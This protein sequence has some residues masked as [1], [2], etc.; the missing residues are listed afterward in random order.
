MFKLPGGV[1]SAFSKMFVYQ[2]HRVLGERRDDA[3]IQAGNR[4]NMAQH[5][6]SQRN[7]GPTT[8]DY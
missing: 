6:H 1:C 7:V 3:N 2:V 8:Y 5:R 4:E